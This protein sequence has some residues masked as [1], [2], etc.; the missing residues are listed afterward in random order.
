MS[1]QN[2]SIRTL[3]KGGSLLL[4]GL[5][6]QLGISF[7]AKL[8]VAR[9]LTL[10][11]FGGVALGLTTASVVGTVAL[12]GLQE[13][14][15]R[16]LPRYDSA[17]DRRGV[18]L[19]G[20][21]TSVPVGLLAGLTL[22]VLAPVLADKIFNSPEIAPV[23]QVFSLVVPLLVV[24]RL[25]ISTIQGNQQSVPKVL[26]E[27]LLRPTTRFLAI[28]GVIIVGISPV[29]IAWAYVIGWAIPALAGLIYLYRE[30]ELFDFGRPA[31]TR[32]REMLRFSIPLLF[33]ATLAMVFNDLDTLLLGYFS[34]TTDP[35]GIYNA[36]YPLGNLLTTGTVAFGFLF[37]PIIS[38]FHGNG[39]M[40]R[41][42]RTYQVVTKWVFIVTFPV[43]L[44]LVAF[45]ERAIALTFGAKYT[46]GAVTL[47]VLAT[48]FFVH[49]VFGLNRETI[50]AVGKTRMKL[51]VDL[52]AAAVN[53]VL[54]LAL[55]PTYGPLGA[56]TATAIT[57][58]GMNVGL[59][60][61][62]YRYSRI[63]PFT[64]AILRPAAL[65]GLAFLVVYTAI[66][67]YLS[68]TV[69]ILVGG[70]A[71]FSAVYGFAILRFGGVQEEEV[72]IVNSVE[73]RFGLDFE[74]A[75]RLV[76]WLM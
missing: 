34:E 35:V 32:H 17:A 38:E 3:F 14:I 11:D 19:S 26:L 10:A 68:P 69:P 25:V 46:G 24:H 50:V 1:E 7:V 40:D 43:F 9:E 73:E 13:G 30:T 28:G 18:L 20:F 23:L 57:F 65:G 5:V 41:A 16:Y 55:I 4:V 62:L 48:G 37:M 33:S 70:Y 21:T 58:V 12:L 53:L 64:A 56:A 52:G 63:V 8:I 36:V 59:S 29:R 74:P 39:D 49:T 22:L 61:Y 51:L 27:N 2:D 31:E 66:R 76:R 15:G 72:L 60:A 42:R 75:K 47:S 67:T 54:N 45:P 44:V 71:V 6:F